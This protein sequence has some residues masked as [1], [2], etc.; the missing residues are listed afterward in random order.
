IRTVSDRL[1]RAP[2]SWI[3]RGRHPI[4]APA[5]ACETISAGMDAAVI[6]AGI[7]GLTGALTPPRAGLPVRVYEQ[8]PS[9]REV[10]A[11]I[12]LAPNAT[13]ILHRLGVAEALGRVAVRPGCTEGK[14]GDGGRG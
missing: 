2:P 12:Q 5:A 6:G 7:G 9:L 1:M 3:R 14:R 4:T 13:R 10:G 8:P 11:G